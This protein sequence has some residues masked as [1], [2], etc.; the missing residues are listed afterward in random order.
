MSWRRAWRFFTTLQKQMLEVRNLAVQ[1][2]TAHAVRDISFRINTGEIHGLIGESGCGKSITGATLLGLLPDNAR[3][4]AATLAI[5]GQSILGQQ[6]RYRGNRI[7]LVSQDPAAALNPVL[8]I[9]RQMDD[10]I[11]RHNSE[12]RR[13]RDRRKLAAQ[14]LGD[15]GLSD[16]EKILAS[17]PHQLSGGMQQRV[18]IAQ[19]LATGAQYLIA[20]EPTTAL[21]VS[22]EAQVLDL[23]SR[24]ASQRGLT[25]LLITH[26]MSVV[27]RCCTT[28]SVVYAGVLVEEGITEQV[29]QSPRHPYTRA[30]IGA[31]PE[32]KPRGAKLQSLAGSVPAANAAFTNCIFTDRCHAATDKCTAVAPPWV[33]SNNQSARCHYADAGLADA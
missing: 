25:I 14:L 10:I 3:A 27:R 11:R 30:L 18:V 20:D 5:D 2:G 33:D 12:N 8:K 32:S 23:F 17:Y 29:L 28:I 22:I 19:A 9:G 1:F 26:D 6:Q 7:T 13:R 15:T 24:L 16:P 31:L 4:T 21:D